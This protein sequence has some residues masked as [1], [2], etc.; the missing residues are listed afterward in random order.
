MSKIAA[1][2]VC[3]RRENVSAVARSL[4]RDFRDSRKV[5]ADRVSVVGIRGTEF[6]KINL[7]IEIQIRFG[8]LTLP[9]ETRVINS[10]AVL[11]PGRAATR[12]RMWHVRDLIRQ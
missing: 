2:A 11:V 1:I 3:H 4:E 9:R 7:L 10:G 6:V 8:S 5:F 12:R